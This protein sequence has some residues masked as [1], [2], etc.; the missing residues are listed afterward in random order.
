MP[1]DPTGQTHSVVTATTAG[2]LPG[3]SGIK[4]RGMTAAKQ[5]QGFEGPSKRGSASAPEARATN[6]SF[7]RSP[8]QDLI[9]SA[10]GLPLINGTVKQPSN[11]SDS[12]SVGS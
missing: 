7:D 12:K 11:R 2:G 4:H 3:F 1:Q 6:A 5:I 9:S 8:Y 10:R